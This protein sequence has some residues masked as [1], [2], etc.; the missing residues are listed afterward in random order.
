[1]VRSKVSKSWIDAYFRDEILPPDIG[2]D[3]S[4]T[5]GHTLFKQTERMAQDPKWYSGNV[6]FPLRPKSEFRY[7]SI[8]HCIQYL[9]RQRPLVNNMLW[10]PIEVFNC[11]GERIYSEINT[12]SW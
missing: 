2:S 11:G 10:D 9:L 6:E 4:F 5:S 7:R 12:G 8:L 3:I 1:M